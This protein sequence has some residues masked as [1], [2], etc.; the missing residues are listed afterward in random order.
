MTDTIQLEISGLRTL[1]REQLDP[2]VLA[3]AIPPTLQKL[4]AMYPVHR[5]DF[6]HGDVRFLKLVAAAA[7]A[8]E[9]FC[10]LIEDIPDVR[11]NAEAAEYMSELSELEGALSHAAVGRRV[12]REIRALRERFPG[13][14]VKA[15]KAARTHRLRALEARAWPCRCGEA[16]TM[17]GEQRGKLYWGCSAYPRCKYTHQLT[18][19]QRSFLDGT[20]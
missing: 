5:D 10:D 18:D 19:Q 16:M 20:A 12:R 8:A 14:A 15:A 4:R 13:A 6:R 7:E 2:R 1:L 3:D 17:R 9:D 11:V